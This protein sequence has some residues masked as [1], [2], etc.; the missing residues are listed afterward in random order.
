M[1]KEY[2][3]RF[4]DKEGNHILSLCPCDLSHENGKIVVNYDI[5]LPNGTVIF[6]GVHEDFLKYFPNKE[7]L[8]DNK[9]PVE[10]WE[11]PD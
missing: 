5:A 10:D 8:L 11:K 2:R 1:H 4:Y 7:L 3:Q 9:E 6:C